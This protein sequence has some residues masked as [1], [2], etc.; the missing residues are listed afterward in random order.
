MHEIDREYTYEFGP[1][2]L[3]VRDHKLLKNGDGVPLTPKAFE[4]LFLLVQQAGRVITKD[5]L[6]SRVW[7]DSFVEE[8]GLTRNISV[9]RKALGSSDDGSGYIE[10][11]PK[12]GYRFT[13]SVRSY[14]FDE[15]SAVHAVHAAGGPSADQPTYA[16][17]MV[18][19]PANGYRVSILLAL[20]LILIV[21]FASIAY[22]SLW[23]RLDEPL[24]DSTRSIAVLP[25]KPLE[26]DS[27]EAG[28]GIGLADA[29]ITR[30]S[31][32]RSLVVKPT[33][34]V[35]RFAGEQV[36]A[37]EAGRQLGV[38]AVLDGGIQRADGR[39]RISV[40]LVRVKD[41]KALWA[42]RFDENA[43]EIFTVQDAIAQKVTAALEI[44][45]NAQEQERLHRRYTNN[46][47]AFDLYLKGRSL[48]SEYTREGTLASIDA[49]ESTLRIE[50]EYALAR[51]GLATACAEMFLRFAPES[52]TEKW[53]ERADDEIQQALELEPEL[54]ETHQALAAVYRKKDF[55][56]EKVLDE[57]IRAIELNPS[58]DQ[59]HFYRAAAFYHMGLLDKALAETE[60]AERLDPENRTDSLRTR[61]VIALYSRRY[62]DAIASF[63]E[64]QKLS[65]KPV[66]DAHLS[67]AYYLQGDT[68]RAIEIVRQLSTDVSA[69]ASSRAKA[70][71]AS[72]LAAQGQKREAT[73]ILDSLLEKH[74]LDH[75]AAYSIGA[76]FAGLG[77]AKR[78]LE[79]LR[80]ATG[81]GLSCYSL[82]E[83][84]KLLDPIRRTPEFQEF[85]IQLGEMRRSAEERYRS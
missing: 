19:R 49:F 64:V 8:A 12:V 13:E 37:L 25:F 61:G 1:F 68:K 63:E 65:S 48:L 76:A 85:L 9:L 24:R 41:G 55:N 59:P 62:A 57:S 39:V 47:Q 35:T 34:A 28:L 45:L 3:D 51:A 50:P 82:Y 38:D 79:W 33:S 10:T 26:G 72:F 75:H 17:V 15:S 18:S 78:A 80:R 52:E 70:S 31:G 2:R 27:R 4:T 14:R 42:Q 71:L 23:P 40:Q 53:A 74:Y 20:G 66:S 56:W 44:H 6:I 83:H 32:I 22:F 5:E 21:G 11:V 77:D 30:L 67:Q 36:S 54:A 69:S 84:D 7:P 73:E 16:A 29:L 81:S 60:A 43:G 58:L 46:V